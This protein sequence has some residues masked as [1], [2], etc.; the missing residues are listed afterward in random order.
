MT[1]KKDCFVIAIDIPG[2][3]EIKCP[4][5]VSVSKPLT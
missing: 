3:W 5:K 1:I 4:G 2:H